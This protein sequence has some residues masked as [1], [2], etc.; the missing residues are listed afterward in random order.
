MTV[1]FGDW[2]L[3]WQQDQRPTPVGEICDECRSPVRAGD[4]GS[5]RTAC[6]PSGHYAAVP[7]HREC[8]PLGVV[9]HNFGVCACTGFEHDRAA[10][11]ELWR[12]MHLPEAEVRKLIEGTGGA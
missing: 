11:L 1:Y 2:W 6:S 7:V 4:R 12:R 3:P 5:W 9:G 10:A 8:E